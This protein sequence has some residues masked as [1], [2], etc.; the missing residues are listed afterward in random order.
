MHLRKTGNEGKKINCW[1]SFYMRALQQQALLI[2]KQKVNEPNPLC[3]LTNIK[4]N[5]LQNAIPTPTQ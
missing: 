1:E 4:D 5:T 3:S 2:D